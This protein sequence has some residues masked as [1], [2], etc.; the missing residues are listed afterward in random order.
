MQWFRRSLLVCALVG[1]A[2]SVSAAPQRDTEPSKGRRTAPKQEKERP[3]AN[4]WTRLIHTIL[5]DIIPAPDS[6]LSVPPG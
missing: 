2:V 4:P 1:M 5:D 6:K 3:P